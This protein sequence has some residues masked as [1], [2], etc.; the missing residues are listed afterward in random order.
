[1]ADLIIDTNVVSYLFKKDSR[2][3]LYQKHLVGH[4]WLISFMTAAELDLW[5]LRHHWGTARK[6]QM[7]IHLRR[8]V[9]YPFNRALCLRWAEAM[10]TARR[11]GRPIQVADAWIAAT[12]LLANASLVTHNPA[13]Y[14]GV[15]GLTVLSEAIP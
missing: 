8:F 3:L 7:E 13:D 1:M 4:R 10:D 12:A 9:L 6:L 5:A 14:A 15:D 2:A 11:K